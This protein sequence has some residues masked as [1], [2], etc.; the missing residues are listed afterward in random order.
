MESTIWYENFLFISMQL[1]TFIDIIYIKSKLELHYIFIFGIYIL[2]GLE[3]LK[4]LYRSHAI[5]FGYFNAPEQ[6]ENQ[7]S[8]LNCSCQFS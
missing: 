5:L 8:G 2:A 6:F 3:L 1:Y 7:D 4:Y